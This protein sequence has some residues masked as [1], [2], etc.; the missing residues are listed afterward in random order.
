[1]T[2]IPDGWDCVRAKECPWGIKP[3]VGMYA[4]FIKGFANGRGMYATDCITDSSFNCPRKSWTEE[5]WKE[6]KLIKLIVSK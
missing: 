3:M 6:Q 5:Q 2:V 4:S 1:M